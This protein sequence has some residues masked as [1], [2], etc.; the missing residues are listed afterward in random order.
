MSSRSL[1]VVV[2][3]TTGN[4][5]VWIAAS[6]SA[7]GAALG[8]ASPLELKTVAL[9]LLQPGAWT[10]TAASTRHVA[11]NR[12]IATSLPLEAAGRLC[13]QYNPFSALTRKV[14]NLGGFV[15]QIS[16]PLTLHTLSAQWPR[17][18]QGA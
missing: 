9:L 6:I 7:T 17:Q 12:A 11:Y 4:P 3:S 1:S 14:L 5:L 15:K 8:L 2:M 16:N 13:R 10:S 18:H